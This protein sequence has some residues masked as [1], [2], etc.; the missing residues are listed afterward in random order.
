[1]KIGG[2]T[3][4]KNLRSCIESISKRINEYKI[5]RIGIPP[6]GT[7]VGRF[8]LRRCAEVMIETI[9]AE[10]IKRRCLRQVLLAVEEEEDFRVFEAVY[11][12][13]TEGQKGKAEISSG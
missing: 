3:S 5:S 8:P 9:L 6:M 2:V 12:S 11:F 10:V 13:I 1:M 7:G 4:E